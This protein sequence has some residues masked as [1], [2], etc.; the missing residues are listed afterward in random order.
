MTASSIPNSAM[1][2]PRRAV[3]GWESPRSPRMKRIEAM[4]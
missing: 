4:K 2:M 3:S 1:N